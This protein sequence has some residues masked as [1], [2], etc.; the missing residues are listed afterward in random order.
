MIA[1]KR[2]VPAR[3][4][5]G[6]DWIGFDHFIRFFQ[7]FKFR[8]IM[9]NTFYLNA[10]D[11]VFGFPIPIVLALIL[12]YAPWQRYRKTVQMV[13]YAPHFISTVVMV[14]IIMKLFSQR[15]GL[16]NVGLMQFGMQ[17]VNFLGDAAWFPHV[18]VWTWHL[19]SIGLGGDHPFGA[20][21]GVDPDLHESAK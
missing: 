1:F 12:H 15:I 13:T 20:A 21:G 11:L 7:S 9:W 2:F 5:L 17:E 6:S 10:Y 19:P 18:Y 4:I 14:G 16:L 8:E 3:G